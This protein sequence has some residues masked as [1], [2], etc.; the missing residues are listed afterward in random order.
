[1]ICVGDDFYGFRVVR[2]EDHPH[3][4]I[5][6]FERGGKHIQLEMSTNDYISLALDNYAKQDIQDAMLK[7]LY[8]IYGGSETKMNGIW[9]GL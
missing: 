3:S 7:Y 1:M 2:S 8:H 6:V 5:W 9:G 4:H